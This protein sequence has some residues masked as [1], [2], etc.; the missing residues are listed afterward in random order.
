MLRVTVELLP[1]NDAENGQ[2]L[3]VMD[4]VIVD[5]RPDGTADYAVYLKKKAPF[6]KVFQQA[7]H[8]GLVTF[9]EGGLTAG[10]TETEDPEGIARVISGPNR[11]KGGIFNLVYRALSACGVDGKRI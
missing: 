11:I 5:G 3:G 2:V 9:K 1:H 10:I 7:K 4:M 8:K 6:G